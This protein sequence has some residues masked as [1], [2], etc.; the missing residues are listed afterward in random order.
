M[1][2]DKSNNNKNNIMKIDLSL[3]QIYIMKNK[4]KPNWKY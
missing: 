2:I 3:P 1:K 4:K